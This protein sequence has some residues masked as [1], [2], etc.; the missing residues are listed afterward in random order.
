MYGSE[1]FGPFA[2]SRLENLSYQN[3]FGSFTKTPTALL[4]VFLFATIGL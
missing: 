1:I 3:C 2:L 4:L